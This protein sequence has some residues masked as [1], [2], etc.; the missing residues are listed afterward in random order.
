MI[1]TNLKWGG[2]LTKNFL[3]NLL[4]FYKPLQ[5]LVSIIIKNETPKNKINDAYFYNFDGCYPKEN[6]VDISAIEL[7]T[8]SVE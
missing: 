1:L 8:T 3:K 2:M 5:L 4:A 6:K 7:K